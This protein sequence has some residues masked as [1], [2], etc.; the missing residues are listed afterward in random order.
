MSHACNEVRKRDVRTEDE[1][2]LGRFRFRMNQNVQVWKLRL[3][4]AMFA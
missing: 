3:V 4:L 2:I 1:E